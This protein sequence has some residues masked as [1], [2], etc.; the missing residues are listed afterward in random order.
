MATPASN[1]A[2]FN[3]VPDFGVS[4]P[5]FRAG[6][7][8]HYV[9][10]ATPQA[11]Q[12]VLRRRRSSQSF[13]SSYGAFG[14][15]S[16]LLEEEVEEEQQ[17][18]HHHH[19]HQ[20]QYHH[21][22]QHA[23]NKQ[24]ASGHIMDY[25]AHSPLHT[26]QHRTTT[27]ATTLTTNSSP[28][29]SREGGGLLLARAP[30]RDLGMNEPRG[31]RVG[32]GR[33]IQSVH[34]RYGLMATSNTPP[35]N[36]QARYHSVPFG[37]EVTPSYAVSL[38][39]NAL[40]RH[41]KRL[42]IKAISS[43]SSSSSS[44]SSSSLVTD[45]G[46]KNLRRSSS[47]GPAV[48]NG[49]H[50]SSSIGTGGGVK[51]GRKLTRRRSTTDVTSTTVSGLLDEL[52]G[53]YSQAHVHVGDE[54]ESIEQTDSTGDNGEIGAESSNT[55]TTVNVNVNSRSPNKR[56]TSS[57]KDM[58]QRESVRFHPG[59]VTNIRLLYNTFTKQYGRGFGFGQ[60]VILCRKL[61]MAVLGSAEYSNLSKKEIF[62]EL[63]ED[64]KEDSQDSG[65]QGKFV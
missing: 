53:F 62:Q 8:P 6:K 20:H 15:K 50:S 23:N 25:S 22:H 37:R 17:Q 10:V 36:M 30:S 11:K 18:H 27:P 49:A 58:L 56:I 5:A 40:L 31:G 4:L 60:Y 44:S 16:R 9:S 55:D 57:M 61:L 12:H 46:A 14:E 64:W 29:M 21:Q 35:H 59:I 32:P 47:I 45:A 38:E 52:R 63:S 42:S 65:P 1:D 19:H 51:S 48:N 2:F 33:G 24:N 28:P 41:T 13:G 54:N 34:V 26:T 39:K 43:P 3:Q 7:K